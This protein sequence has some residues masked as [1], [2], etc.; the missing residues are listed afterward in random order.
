MQKKLSTIPPQIFPPINF[1]SFGKAPAR[2]IT[3]IFHHTTA[4]VSQVL[5]V[6][7][8]IYSFSTHSPSPPPP[9][10][11]QTFFLL[12]VSVRPRW[13]LIYFFCPPSSFLFWRHQ[14]ENAPNIFYF[15][16]SVAKKNWK[17]NS[18]YP[19]RKHLFLLARTKSLHS[20]RRRTRYNLVYSQ[21]LLNAIPN[22]KIVYPGTSDCVE[23]RVKLLVT[24][25]TSTKLKINTK[26][27]CR[28]PVLSMWKSKMNWNTVLGTE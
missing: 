4:K 16:N 3:I 18:I 28:F 14:P 12:F 8:A 7:R 25:R 23:E 27:G 6:N 9:P 15:C 1:F 24:V 26:R 10:K 5:L 21:S 20:N 11:C 2:I 19:P 17:Q 13:N 22:D